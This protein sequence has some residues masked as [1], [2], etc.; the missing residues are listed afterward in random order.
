MNTNERENTRAW[1]SRYFLSIL[2]ILFDNP[3]ISV[4]TFAQ[5]Y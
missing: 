1:V 3:I 2:L 4:K 5:I